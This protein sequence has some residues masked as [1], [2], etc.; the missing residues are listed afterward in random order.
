MKSSFKK[1]SL[2]ASLMEKDDLK[3]Q[4][5]SCRNQYSAVKTTKEYIGEIMPDD[6]TEMKSIIPD[7]QIKKIELSMND[8]DKIEEIITD[9]A[10]FQT[11][12]YRNRNLYERK[13]TNALNNIKDIKQQFQ[14]EDVK[15]NDQKITFDKDAVKPLISFTYDALEKSYNA[16]Q[17]KLNN[18][19]KKEEEKEEDK[20]E[21]TKTDKKKKKTTHRRVKSQDDISDK[22]E[23]NKKSVEESV[24]NDTRKKQRRGQEDVAC[25][26]GIF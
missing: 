25:R 8:C 2:K 18:E 22:Y 17:Q 23:V 10:E 9:F 14:D 11:K 16:L 13:C 20:K 21:S 12:H 19:N 1:K 7:K 3:N 15:E 6:V 4:F 26:C 24:D 5:S